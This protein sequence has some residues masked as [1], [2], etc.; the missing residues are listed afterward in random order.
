MLFMIMKN[1]WYL[2]AMNMMSIMKESDNL[3]DIKSLVK[4]FFLVSYEHFV[5]LV[6]LSAP[7]HI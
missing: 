3:S 5:S 2:K 6:S 7:R 1:I 4:N